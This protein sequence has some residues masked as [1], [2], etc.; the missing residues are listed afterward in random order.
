MAWHLLYLISTL[1]GCKK[2]M[3]LTQEKINQSYGGTNEKDS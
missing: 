2:K 3:F 1:R